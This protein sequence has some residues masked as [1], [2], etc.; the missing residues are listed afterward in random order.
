MP[1]EWT[2]DRK[3]K[4][5]E[6]WKNGKS[7]SAIANEMEVSRNAILG[8][9]HRAKLKRTYG[10]ERRKGGRGT[11]TTAKIKSR[12][13]TVSVPNVGGDKKDGQAAIKKPARNQRGRPRSGGDDR[14]GTPPP[15]EPLFAS[16]RSRSFIDFRNISIPKS[17]V[18]VKPLDLESHHCRWPIGDPRS[19]DFVHCGNPKMN[20]RPY[21]KSCLRRAIAPK[22]G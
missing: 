18:G 13:R 5:I 4:A 15:T 9:I 19:P 3:D 21:C 2:K 6:M 22:I 20:G 10:G 12:K 7:A 8:L 17:Y 11:G 16:G 14:V 1:K